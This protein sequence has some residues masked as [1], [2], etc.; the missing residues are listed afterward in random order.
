[1]TRDQVVATLGGPPGDY[2][3]PT[4]DAI[5]VIDPWLRD[6]RLEDEVWWGDGYGLCVRFDHDGRVAKKLFLGGVRIETRPEPFWQRLLK[7]PG[8]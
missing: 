3:N 4:S 8:L 7:R 6:D 1:M 2:T 5:V